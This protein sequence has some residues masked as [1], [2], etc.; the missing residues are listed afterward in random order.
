MRSRRCRVLLLLSCLLASSAR[1]AEP[2]LTKLE[3]L[4]RGKPTSALLLR[5][6]EAR[7]L[8]VLAHGQVM[9][10]HH[11]FMEAISAALARHGVATLRFNFPYAEAKQEQPDPMPVLIESAVA[12]AH[13]GEKRRGTLPLLLGGKSVG[14]MIAALAVQGDRLPG[15]KGVVL[16]T[17]P[18][19][20]PGRPSALNAPLLEAV[21]QPMLL[22]EG[23][24]DPLADLVLMK[25]VV[26]KIG[27]RAQLHVVEGADH[28]FELEEGGRTQEEVYAEVAEAVASFA[29]TLAQSQGG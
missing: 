27:A 1:A 12:A 23:T 15:V 3:I 6:A 7:A 2:E 21:E 25:A 19:H 11:P 28:G 17:F 14:A 13:E 22:V 16:L 29:A 4:V 10:M 24:R 5:P 9:D 20:T 18:L 8:L 26:E